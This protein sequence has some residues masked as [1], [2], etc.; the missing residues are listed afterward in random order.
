[1]KTTE[2]VRNIKESLE[3]IDE[4]VELGLERRQRSL[5]FHVSVC[6]TEL[7]ELYLHKAGLLDE[8]RVLKHT[9][10]SSLRR[11]RDVLSFAFPRKEE[12]IEILVEIEKRRNVLCYGKRKEE[13]ELKEYLNLFMRLKRIMEEE[14]V[15]DEI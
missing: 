10:F 11:A 4:A 5:G 14:G 1:M 7:V 13:D 15:M 6:A 8:S 2:H 3:E 12:V 9:D